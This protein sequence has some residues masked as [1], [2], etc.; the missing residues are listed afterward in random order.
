MV[1]YYDGIV[2]GFE[3]VGGGTVVKIQHFHII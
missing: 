2:I 3:T 1:D